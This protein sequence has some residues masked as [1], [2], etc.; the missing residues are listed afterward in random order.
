MWHVMAEL[1]AVRSMLVSRKSDQLE[2][3]HV[4]QGR[5][6]RLDQKVFV[7]GSHMKVP[8]DNIR[9]CKILYIGIL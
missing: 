3:R 1:W 6:H 4:L 8:R 7:L 9:L 2:E 5:L